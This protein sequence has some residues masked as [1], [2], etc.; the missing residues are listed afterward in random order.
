M[1]SAKVAPLEEIRAKLSAEQREL[2]SQGRE[3]LEKLANS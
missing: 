1:S 3:I 2:F